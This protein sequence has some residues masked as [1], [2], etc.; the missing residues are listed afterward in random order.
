MQSCRAARQL[1]QLLIRESALSSPRSLQ[2]SYTH[3]CNIP[4]FHR[5]LIRGMAGGVGSIHA[6]ADAGSYPKVLVSESPSTPSGCANCPAEGQGS[7][8]SAHAVHT[9]F[10]WCPPPRWRL[11]QASWNLFPPSSHSSGACP[12]TFFCFPLSYS[13]SHSSCLFRCGAPAL[14]INPKSHSSCLFRC[15]VPALTIS[16]RS[17]N[18]TFHFR[19]SA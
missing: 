12:L 8:H 10:C 17:L 4:R 11:F 13:A 9:C 2:V 19:A 3:L 5:H 14:Q 1:L 6:R 18:A 7:M 15:R 16:L